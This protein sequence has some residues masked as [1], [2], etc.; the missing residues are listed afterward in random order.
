MNQ[1]NPNPNTKRYMF[2]DGMGSSN[3][4]QDSLK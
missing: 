2:S 1:F 4:Q 3:D